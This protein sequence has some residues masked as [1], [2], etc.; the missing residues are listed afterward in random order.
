VLVKSLDQAMTQRALPAND[1]T[2]RHG[3][4]F[5]AGA[6]V[7]AVLG[8]QRPEHEQI[9]VALFDDGEAEP[10]VQVAGRVVFVDR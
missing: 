9:G 7:G 10:F 4:F 3:E 8:G 2:A 5:P 6:D 1:R